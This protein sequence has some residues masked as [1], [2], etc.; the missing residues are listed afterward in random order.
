MKTVKFVSR[1]HRRAG[2]LLAATAMALSVLGAPQVAAATGGGADGCI[3][4]SVAGGCRVWIDCPESLVGLA[5]V[6][7]YCTVININGDAY[8]IYF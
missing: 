1:L 8:P 5:I 3:E 7:R 6:G 2:V 4:W